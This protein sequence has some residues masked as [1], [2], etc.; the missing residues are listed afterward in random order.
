MIENIGIV[1]IES[2][3][4]H[5]ELDCGSFTLSPNAEEIYKEIFK[6][7]NLDKT[8]F[9]RNA[10]FPYQP[11]MRRDQ[12]FINIVQHFGSNT[13]TDCILSIM[14]IDKNMSNFYKIEYNKEKKTE[15]VIF[16]EDK[17]HLYLIAKTIYYS[18]SDKDVMY[19]LN[20]LTQENKILKY[21]NYQL[22]LNTV[23]YILS[24]DESV[25][26]KIFKLRKLLDYDMFIILS[27]I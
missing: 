10:N 22:S 1:Y 12:K 13:C 21:N 4:S 18:L 5:Y 24:L 20:I 11:I 26:E 8:T 2:I 7:K 25:S 27:K 19:N 3:Y 15:K 9:S 14:W 16:L 6:N 17:Y 23:S